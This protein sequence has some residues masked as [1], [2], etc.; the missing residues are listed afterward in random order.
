MKS[1]VKTLM[2]YKEKKKKKT[3]EDKIILKIAIFGK[4]IFQIISLK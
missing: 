3:K 4:H 2:P 1:I